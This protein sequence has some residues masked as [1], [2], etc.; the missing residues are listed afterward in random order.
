MFAFLSRS[1]TTCSIS[2][3]SITSY[4]KIFRF[5]NDMV[6]V[7]N[8]HSDIVNNLMMIKR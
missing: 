8:Y 3:K 6:K 5:F 1:W 2:V 7:R 4:Y